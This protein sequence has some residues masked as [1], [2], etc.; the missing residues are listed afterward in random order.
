M[1][2]DMKSLLDAAEKR[3][4]A[5]PAFNV[6]NA[7]T[8]MGVL[9]AAEEARSAVILQMYSRLFSSYEAEFMAP[10][11]VAAA[12]RAKIKV[13]FHLD[14]GASHE[15]VARAIRCGCTSVMRDASELPLDENISELRQVVRFAHDMGISVE[16]ELGHI[17]VAAQGVSR[18][19]TK[20]DEAR[21]FVAETGV[22]DTMQ[23]MIC[24]LVGTIAFL[25]SA[26][27]LGKGKGDWLTGAVSDFIDQNYH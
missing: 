8:A 24:C 4:C 6:Y 2:V 9:F 19:Y 16:G 1:L 10:A 7:E 26:V 25:P 18:D 14:H 21:R 3:G 17:G 11:I 13:A 20:V 15:I 12:Q 22:S 27:H 23:D 5:I